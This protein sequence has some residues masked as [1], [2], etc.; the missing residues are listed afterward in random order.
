[1]RARGPNREEAKPRRAKSRP[2][3]IP[4]LGD[5][6]AQ[7]SWL[8]VY[9]EAR[10][11]HHR[12]P[13]KLCDAIARFGAEASSDVLRQRARCTKCALNG[14]TLRLPSWVDSTAGHA[15][16]PESKSE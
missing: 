5:L 12:A 7:T 8:W 1:M 2:G 9:C 15:P 10:D 11:C 14:A 3:P 13:L 6:A 16:F 4:T